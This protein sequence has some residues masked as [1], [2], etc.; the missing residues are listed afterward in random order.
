MPE[1]AEVK[2]V[3][4]GLSESTDLEKLKGMNAT[5][6]FDIAG[7]DGGVWTVEVTD[8]NISIE[9]GA[10]QSADVTVA[11]TSEDLIALIKGDLNP[12]G[13]FMQGRL[14]VK[15]DMSVAMQLQKLFAS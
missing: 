13:A 4:E 14:K 5:I 11:A 9:E 7:A 8:G 2:Q 15:G 3:L 10:I 1:L 6:V 12:M